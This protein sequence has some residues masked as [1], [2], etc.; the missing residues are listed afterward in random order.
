M[1]KG[2]L[3]DVERQLEGTPT[4]AGPLPA[5]AMTQRLTLMVA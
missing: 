4:K 2:N 3:S 5:T 1:L